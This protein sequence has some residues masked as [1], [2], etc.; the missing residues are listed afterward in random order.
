MTRVWGAGIF[1][2]AM[3]S[4]ALWLAAS[5]CAPLVG[6]RAKR[7]GLD[8]LGWADRASRLTPVAANTGPPLGWIWYDLARALCGR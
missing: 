3:R 4:G 7:S 6:G 2:D 5:L 1:G 8:G